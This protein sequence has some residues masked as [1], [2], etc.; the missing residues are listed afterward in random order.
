MAASSARRTLLAE[1]LS[2]QRLSGEPAADAVEATRHLLAIQA[3]DPRGARLAVRARSREASAAAVDAALTG[4][5]SLLISWF[6]RGTLHLVCSEDYAWLHRLTA[7]TL[8]RANAYG[9]ARFGVSQG[10]LD[11]ALA[12]IERALLDEGPQTRAALLERLQRIGTPNL[13]DAHVHVMFAAAQ[14]GVVVRGPMVGK[15][16]AY[17]HVRD[18]L[19][20]PPRL[21]D[22]DVLLAELARRY[23]AGHSPAADHDLARWAGLPLR[24]ARAGLRAIAGE[25]APREDGLLSLR[26]VPLPPSPVP[27]PRLLGAFDPVL[28]G[29]KSREFVCGRNEARI[30]SGGLF[31]PFTL[32]GGKV[33]GVWRVQRDQIEVEHFEPVSTRAKAALARDA[34][35]VRRYLELS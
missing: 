19:G 11:R 30:I 35:A 21:P 31:R 9:L 12:E 17:V 25:L 27:P 14:R 5:R 4:E 8:A 22:R 26:A 24:D 6:C 32:V 7:P 13:S 28:V 2:A 15:Q 3:Q 1:R 23:L 33:A 34:Q 18:W 10:Q 16:H 29:W 20:K